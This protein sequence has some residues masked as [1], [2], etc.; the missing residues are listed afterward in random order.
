MSVTIKTGAFGPIIPRELASQKPHDLYYDLDQTIKI[1]PDDFNIQK[2]SGT[3]IDGRMLLDLMWT[4]KTFDIKTTWECEDIGFLP[5]VQFLNGQSGENTAFNVDIFN[6]EIQNG[7]SGASGATGYAPWLTPLPETPWT[8]S[9]LIAAMK[10][11]KYVLDPYPVNRDQ[12]RA[13][14]RVNLQQF[15]SIGALGFGRTIATYKDIDSQ[16]DQ[17]FE[18]FDKEWED[19][20]NEITA[21]KTFF[22]NDF[23]IRGKLFKNDLE[24]QLAS[25]PELYPV[26]V[27]I[28]Y[29]RLEVIESA[30]NNSQTEG[31]KR[32]AINEILQLELGLLEHIKSEK[33]L[34]M[35]ELMGG[36]KNQVDF[37][38]WNAGKLFSE[39]GFP[40]EGFNGFPAVVNGREAAT[41]ATGETSQRNK[42]KHDVAAYLQPIVGGA[43]RSYE[44]YTTDVQIYDPFKDNG[45]GNP[46][47]GINI[48]QVAMP[49]EI[50]F[51]PEIGS[52][53]PF[54]LSPTRISPYLFNLAATSTL[55]GGVAG[56]GSLAF[57][58]GS[59]F[60]QKGESQWAQV[61]P[62][63]TN[64]TP[65][66]VGIDL[67]DGIDDWN[68]VIYSGFLDYNAGYTSV[69][70]FLDRTASKVRQFVDQSE[71]VGEV[72]KLRFLNE[73]GGL[74]VE[75]PIYGSINIWKNV[76][77]EYKINQRW[78]FPE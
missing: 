30:W 72:G 17:L 51:S 29:E 2:T 26:Y 73:T 19:W 4:V 12:A 20:T 44:E 38:S 52:Y 47:G 40:R 46:P 25:I 16:K 56:N 61:V 55:T 53:Q 33:T 76:T 63:L 27:S 22:E 49:S 68:T 50:F 37:F 70:D 1:V 69:T 74:I 62:P 57:E 75:V 23:S 41:G 42:H 66:V 10:W 13:Q 48:E 54:S 15:G 67:P 77:I 35:F 45:E 9:P 7:A 43:F 34:E 39:F 59:F 58:Y 36:F 64:F 78:D 24:R 21:L 32:N 8:N 60:N 65:E 11:T 6:K 3:E 31:Q 71:I 14:I 18:N 5:N 28:M